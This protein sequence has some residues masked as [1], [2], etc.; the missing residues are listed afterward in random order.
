MFDAE[1][2]RDKSEVERWKERDPIATFKRALKERGLA[3]DA[4]IAALDGSVSNEISRAVQFA[5]AG[6][7]E[8]IEDLLND[9]YTS[10]DSRRGSS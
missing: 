8:P 3:T 9:V 5:E 1:L 7:W 2:Y 4:A 10:A 6:T